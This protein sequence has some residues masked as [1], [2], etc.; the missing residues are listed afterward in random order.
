MS[1]RLIDSPTRGYDPHIGLVGNSG[2]KPTSLAVVDTS[3]ILDR[4]ARRLRGG[5]PLPTPDTF[6]GIGSIRLFAPMRVAHELRW[7]LGSAARRLG[8][9]RDALSRV[10]TTDF[11][12]RT[13]FV[14]LPPSNDLY[15][16]RLKRLFKMDP[17]DIDL[18]R[19]GLLLAPSHVYSHDKH[20]RIAG[21]SLAIEDLD[22]VLAAGLAIEVSD[23]ALVTTGFAV[24]AGAAGVSGAAKGIAVRLE[25]PLWV[26]GLIAALLVA[27]GVWWSLSTPERRAK[28][29]EILLQ[30]A[31]PATGMA[32]R[33]VAGKDLL[34]RTSLRVPAPSLENR[35]FRALAVARGPLLAG[36]I[37]ALLAESGD[38]PAVG[39]VRE[40][41]ASHAAFAR[42]GP[43]RWQLGRQLAPLSEDQL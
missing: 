30:L 18:G 32:E 10:V 41:L 39:W 2:L 1:I 37:H 6:G 43:H 31:G 25:V 12:T 35:I 15:D 5:T 27:G 13:R 8:V 34:D 40:F 3:Y 19:L 23:G 16:E 21:F 14:D 4:A 17:E 24:R 9:P 33:R 7:T 36:E 20:L 22:A 29:Q 38:A 42:V 26:V 11:I 28:A